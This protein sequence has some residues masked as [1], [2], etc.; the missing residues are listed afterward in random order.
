[1]LPTCRERSQCARKRPHCVRFQ[2]KCLTRR[3]CVHTIPCVTQT[4]SRATPGT[5]HDPEVG[6]RARRSFGE[7][8]R[9]TRADRGLIQAALGSRLGVSTGTVRRYEAGAFFPSLAVLL[10]LRRTL[11]VSL[12]YL[13]AGAQGAA[14]RHLGL[15]R[16]VRALDALP[17]EAIEE[18]LPILDAYLSRKSS[19]PA[20]S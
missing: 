2:L 19:P 20:T 10:E 8:L 3:E 16:R 18:I 4:D 13:L 6:R 7:R 17:N 1:M 12:D 9:L 15:A 11:K 5:V 14:V